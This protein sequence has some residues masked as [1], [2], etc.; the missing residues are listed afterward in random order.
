MDL[1]IQQ[2]PTQQLHSAHLTS[3]GE[4]TQDLLNRSTEHR[5]SIFPSGSRARAFHSLAWIR[6]LSRRVLLKVCIYSS[7][8]LQRG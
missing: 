4:M 6:A 1:V 5:D 2:T 8:H 7:L 3:R